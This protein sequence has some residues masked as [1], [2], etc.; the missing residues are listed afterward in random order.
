MAKA[1]GTPKTG[2]RVAGTPNRI[3]KEIRLWLFDLV[4]NNTDALEK[5][6][7]SMD[8]RE[9]WSI[10]KEVLPYVITKRQPNMYYTYEFPDGEE[11]S[12]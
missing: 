3:P 9:R 7:E 1:K 6:F 10:I 5:D 11:I 4:Q 8:S 2:G 12:I